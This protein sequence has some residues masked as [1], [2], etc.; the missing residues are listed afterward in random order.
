[1]RDKYLSD[2]CLHSNVWFKLRGEQVVQRPRAGH[3][4]VIGVFGVDS[5]LERVTEY[6]EV[7]LCERQR[8]AR[9]Y[10]QL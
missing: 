4:G 2:T 5:S 3:E 7:I 8:L 1:M 10:S 9:G 6:G